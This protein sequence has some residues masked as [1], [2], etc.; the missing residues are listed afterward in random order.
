MDKIY[1][2]LKEKN[3]FTR[4]FDGFLRCPYCLGRKKQAYRYKD[5]LQHATGVGNCLSGM[6]LPVPDASR[7]PRKEIEGN[8]EA[9]CTGKLISDKQWKTMPVDNNVG[10]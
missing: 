7:V 2:E 5:L 10:A 3:L 1:K 6:S 9:Y 4:S 8:R